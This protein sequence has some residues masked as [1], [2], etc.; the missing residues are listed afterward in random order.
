[1]CQIMITYRFRAIIL[2][3]ACV[4]LVSCVPMRNYENPTEPVFVGN[5]SDGCPVFEGT[6]KVVTYN[7]SFA[8]NVELAIR[9]L[10]ELTNLKDADI[11]LL[12]EMDEAG[13]EAIARALAYNF[14]YV[15]ASI[16]QPPQKKLRQC[17]LV[18]MA[19]H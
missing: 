19:H 11:I 3:I 4:Q 10:D 5:F 16:L 15:P 14:V 1:M 2:L 6:I 7:I 13:T 9:E 12:Q 18:Q 17:H 8:R